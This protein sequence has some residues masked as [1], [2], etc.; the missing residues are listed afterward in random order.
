MKAKHLLLAIFATLVLAGCYK[1][2]KLWDALDE[3]QQRIEALENWQKVVNSNIEALQELVSGKHFITDVTP[4]TLE[5]EIVGYTIA[6]FD[7][8][9]ITI[10][11]GKQG[12]K[13]D[14]G[15]QG[16]AGS[17]PVISITQ[18]PDGNWYWTLN[19]ELLTDDN[20]NPIRL[21]GQN[22]TDGK[23]GQP[24]EP[25]QDGQDGQPGKDAPPPY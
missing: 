11:N 24:G 10:Y 12:D 25:G 14:K 19:G 23:P 20:G 5:G 6:F 3:Q 18:Q 15:E 16:P 13:G 2:D 4:V 8:V 1:D 22:G 9:S 17:T 7:H 21:N